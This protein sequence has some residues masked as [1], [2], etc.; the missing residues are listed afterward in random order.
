MKRI[1]LNQGD[2][3]KLNNREYTIDT[4]IGDGATCIVYSAYY[5]DNLGLPHRVNIKECYPY[6]ADIV[7]YGNTLVWKSDAERVHNLSAFS[8]AYKK[9]MSTQKGNFVVHAF[10][11]D[12][13]NETLYIVM[14]ANDGVTFDNDNTDN[15]VDILKTV[16]LLSYVVGEYHKSGYLHLDIKPSNF[17]VYPRPSDHTILFDMDTITPIEDI[18]SG[19]VKVCCYSEDWA[20]PEQKQGKVSKLCPATD[21]YAIGA[22]LFEKVMDRQVECGDSC[23]FAEWDF[24]GDL[25]EDVNPKIKRLLSNIFRKTLSANI[26]RR[27]QSADALIK[28][29]DEAIKVASCDVYL[30]GDD[31]CCSGCFFG[32]E[33]ELALIKNHFDS[34]KKAVFL[35]GF[36][37]IGKTEIARRYAELNSKSYYTVLFIKYNGNDTLQEIIND[38][39]IVN[40]DTDDGKEKW[41]KLRSLLDEHT[42]VIVDNFDVEI[43]VDNGLKALFETKAHILIATRTDFNS[44]YNGDKYAYIEIKE[45]VTNELEQV[46]VANAKITAFTDKDRVILKKIFKLIGNHTYAT[47]LLAKQMWYSGWS[48]EELYQKVKSGFASFEN[49]E[50]I[51]VNKDERFNSNDN[52]F[53]ILRTVYNIS[54]LT[55][56]QKQVLRDMVILDCVKVTRAVYREIALMPMDAYRTEKTLNTI[57][58]H[59]IQLADDIYAKMPDKSLNSFNQLVDLGLVLNY[60]EHF[61]LHSIIKELAF[62]ELKP[63]LINCPAIHN[64]IFRKIERLDYL[65]DATMVDQDE[66][67]DICKFISSIFMV[68]DLTVYEHL[69]L[70]L[71]WLYL[72]YD[73]VNSFNV[74][75]VFCNSM[76]HIEL[77]TRLENTVSV[78]NKETQF[79]VLYIIFKA[80]INEYDY[81]YFGTEENINKRTN[82][83]DSMIINYFLK[84]L[85]ASENDRKKLE[86]IYFEISASAN[87]FEHAAPKELVL[88]AYTKHP[89]LLS[90]DINSKEY[91]G[92]ELTA[93]EI[94]IKKQQEQESVEEL[95][96]MAEVHNENT[97]DRFDEEELLVEGF[98]NSKNKVAFAENVATNLK[99]DTIDRCEFLYAFID[100][101]L[102]KE[103]FLDNNKWC[104]FEKILITL[105]R[106][107]D[108]IEKWDQNYS[109]YLKDILAYQA[110][111]VLCNRSNE[112]DDYM[113]QVLD[114]DFFYMDSPLCREYLFSTSLYQVYRWCKKMGK[115]YAVLPYFV[116]IIKSEL[117][118]R[119]EF[120]EDT[121][122]DIYGHL[123]AIQEYAEEAIEETKDDP[124][125][126]EIHNN[127]ISTY[128]SLTSLKN[129]A[130][131]KIKMDFRKEKS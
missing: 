105:H 47:E 103:V 107:I 75:G 79:K 124:L 95:K 66:A 74:S 81:V 114:I 63:S 71:R 130:I 49:T 51:S 8:T 77:F 35:H 59:K 46:F 18:K 6:N 29:L 16:K 34:K 20:A 17:L 52:S 131:N 96:S 38:I 69:E 12:K 68:I 4:V 48:I 21:I 19:K 88:T 62:L 129:K 113:E 3:I 67:T 85:D 70:V 119:D 86:D 23:L 42:L 127:C 64:Y 106:I 100:E 10:N 22:V 54:S 58:I 2:K 60:G 37:G 97:Y 90:L 89:K 125:L 24:D 1:P 39:D 120:D 33:T 28:N 7:R 44:V 78:F 104:E 80:Y 102:C 93:E 53:N 128:E 50:N 13:Y 31:I 36:G 26:K 45:L 57:E 122:R 98:R 84:A 65:E 94:L 30:K 115:G 27:Y 83:I 82:L 55:E 110:V 121:L 123:T 91:Y 117:S 101:L 40:F 5:E 11:I 92:F 76:K 43:G 126:I 99:Y 9:L 87:T 25:F 61:T 112:F 14:D 73:G 118:D 32:R 41:R 72:L 108:N 56:G 109:G 15:L 111:Y 116:K